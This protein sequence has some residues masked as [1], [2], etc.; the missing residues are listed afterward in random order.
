LAYAY[1][2]LINITANTP[3][4]YAVTS[5]SA[6][7]INGSGVNIYAGAFSSFGSLAG[8][9]YLWGQAGASL[10]SSAGPPAAI[11]PLTVYIYGT[12]GTKIDGDVYMARISNIPGSNIDIHPDSSNW[13][14]MLRVQKIGMGNNPVIDG[15]G[16]N[17]KIS[18]FTSISATGVSGTTG[19]FT[20]LNS[21]TITPPDLRPVS[22]TDLN[23]QSFYQAA[24]PPLIAEQK[25]SI[26]LNS[27][28]NINLNPSNG[29]KV[30]VNG[31]DIATNNW[32][33]IPATQ[34]PN[35]SNYGL[36]NCSFVTASGALTLNGT[37][38]IIPETL[39]LSNNN[40][41]NCGTINGGTILTNPA[42]ADL[43][44][45]NNSI[46]NVPSIT[47]GFAGSLTLGSSNVIV[48]GRSGIN[49][50][51]SIGAGSNYHFINMTAGSPMTITTSNA[52]NLTA[53]NAIGLTGSLVNIYS[54][55]NMNSNNLINVGT[56]N[57]AYF[58]TN[59]L[60]SNLNAGT[61]S[62]SNCGGVSSPSILQL[63]G[64]TGVSILN[65]LNLGS[66]GVINT[67]SLG[68]VTT[69]NGGVPITSPVSANLNM[70]DYDINNVG[71]ITS[72]SDI[73]ISTTGSNITL[74]SA[75]DIDLNATNTLVSGTL[76]AL[77]TFNR[78]LGS[79]PI[80]QPIQQYGGA[81]GTGNSGSVTVT[82][83]TAYT[84]TSSYR[85]FVTHSGTSPANYSAANINATSF[86]IYW[87][88]AGGG[89]QNFNWFTVG[90]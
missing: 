37:S 56:I 11:N 46:S 59:P 64:T 90:T 28:Y 77:G 15:G 36:S 35:L 29:G 66:Y 73:L 89:A 13:V 75:T 27:G 51:V 54:Q 8:Q 84:S 60:T 57:G 32:A 53:S 39:N 58:L 6:V 72:T 47:G 71:N 62:I 50:A 19:Y 23:L 12:N 40:I 78:Q 42:A 45:G 83:P 68:G 34:S 16:A 88:N 24:I 10:T 52:F 2:G 17:A 69:I 48:T 49:G 55:L 9:L 20:T 21:T 86:N 79:T 82:L 87:T 61:Y 1:G 7:K 26:N 4:A 30:Y 76:N 67:G 25:Y 85:V 63:N 33:A 22:S 14:D 18:N 81:S 3:T 43:N 5:T 38:V 70:A 65:T 44:M 41:I 74:A 31:V 80:A